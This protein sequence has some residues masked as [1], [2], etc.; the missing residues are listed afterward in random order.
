MRRAD[1]EFGIA[2]VRNSLMHMIS[3]ADE[4]MAGNDHEANVKKVLRIIR[5]A[6]R[7]GHRELLRQV[8]AIRSRDLQ[9]IIRNL[10]EDGSIIKDEVE[11]KGRKRYDYVAK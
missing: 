1:V 10:I 2:M 7:I 6:G 4:Y 3:G 5:Q 9:D 11:T 8:R